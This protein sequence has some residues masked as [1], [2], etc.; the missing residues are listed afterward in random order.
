[1]KNIKK[2]D[3]SLIT[4]FYI[5]LLLF[6]GYKRI[7][8][9]VSVIF[10]VHELGHIFFAKLFGIKINKIKIYPFG[11]I[12]DFN[13]RINVSLFIDFITAIGGVLFQLVLLIINTLLLKDR[14]FNYYNLLIISLNILPIIPLDGSKILLAL[15]NRFISYFKSLIIINVFSLLSLIILSTHMILNDS[16]NIVLISFIIT[17]IFKDFKDIKRKM[18]AFFM[19]RYIGNIQFKRSK[20]FKK[21]NLNLLKREELGYFYENK[22]QDEKYFIAKRFDIRTYF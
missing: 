2:V 9:R 7:L 11:G 14:A 16:L 19:E 21:I 4:Y 13:K 15:L 18:T 1:M 8:L 12:I 5:L 10:I 6:S 20:K 17:S 22:W 3:I